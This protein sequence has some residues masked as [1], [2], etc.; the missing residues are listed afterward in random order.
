M[1]WNGGM[2]YWNGSINAKKLSYF[3]NTICGKVLLEKN[4]DKW[5]NLNQLEDK[6]LVNELQV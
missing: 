3:I 6:I 2:K 4:I 1:K 5:A